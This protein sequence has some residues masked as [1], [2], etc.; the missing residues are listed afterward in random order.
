[1]GMGD[2]NGEEDDLPLIWWMTA[3]DVAQGRDYESYTESLS[4]LNPESR[5]SLGGV[6]GMSQDSADAHTGTHY[7]YLE[8]LDNPFTPR[9]H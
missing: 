9:S 2:E 3:V 4:L 1:M 6:R 8:V 7:Y 5:A